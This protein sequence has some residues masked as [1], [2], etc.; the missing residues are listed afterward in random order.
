MI[1]FDLE[2]QEIE[3]LLDNGYEIVINKKTKEE[4]LKEK[5][6]KDRASRQLLVP[7]KKKLT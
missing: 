5:E 1:L 3:Y 7:I 6:E 4:L 2:I